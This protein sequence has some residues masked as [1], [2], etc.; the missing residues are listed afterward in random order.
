V[1]GVLGVNFGS[2]R[3]LSADLGAVAD[4]VQASDAAQPGLVAVSA[5]MATSAS[6]QACAS[7]AP[8]VK[9]AL[10]GLGQRLAL[11]AGVV[12]EAAVIYARAEAAHERNLRALGG[13]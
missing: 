4:T 11:T 8:T 3:T 12:S 1:G 6:G 13:L 5:A 9:A 7:A 10:T 2:L